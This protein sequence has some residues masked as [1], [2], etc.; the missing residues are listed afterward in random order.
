MCPSM[1]GPWS[2]PS[3]SKSPLTGR[4]IQLFISGRPVLKYIISLTNI[5]PYFNRSNEIA[6]FHINTKSRD[7]VFIRVIFR[8]EKEYLIYIT[9]HT[10]TIMT[11]WII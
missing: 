8:V 2:G 1:S 5:A 3:W 4:T 10:L 9:C 11:F 7:F 6:T